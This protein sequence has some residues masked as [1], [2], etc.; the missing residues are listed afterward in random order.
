MSGILQGA[1]ISAAGELAATCVVKGLAPDA[2][3]AAFFAAW[4]AFIAC[5]AHMWLGFLC[6]VDLSSTPLMDSVLKSLVN[7]VSV[8]PLLTAF[9]LIAAAAFLHGTPL[10]ELADVHAL[11]ATVASGF[12]TRYAYSA[13]FWL[14]SDLTL[15][16]VVPTQMRVAWVLLMSAVWS[17]ISSV[18][19]P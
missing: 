5:N 1:A 11:S 2:A 14:T 9:F 3:R 13:S 16:T 18:I 12:S 6:R 4:G 10:L 7:Q 15:F 8:L 19:T 17:V